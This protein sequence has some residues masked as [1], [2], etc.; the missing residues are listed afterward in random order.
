MLIIAFIVL[1]VYAGLF[2]AVREHMLG[3]ERRIES[4]EEI[5]MWSKRNLTERDWEDA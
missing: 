4:L 3:L 1:F 2:A 5:E